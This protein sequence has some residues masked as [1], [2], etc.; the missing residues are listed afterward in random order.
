M[1]R[2][3]KQPAFSQYK[4]SLCFKTHIMLLALQW[5]RKLFQHR[6]ALCKLA[7]CM[8]QIFLSK[9]KL[10]Q[11]RQTGRKNKKLSKTQFDYDQADRPEK[12]ANL[13]DNREESFLAKTLFINQKLTRTTS[14]R[15]YSF[16]ARI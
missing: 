7:S 12:L 13:L 9:L 4:I 6:A 16:T 11:P 5:W 10:L 3:Q 1:G 8:R 15:C 14:T 2:Q